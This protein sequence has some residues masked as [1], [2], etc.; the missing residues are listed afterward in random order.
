MQSET[1]GRFFHVW[2]DFVGSEFG[3][4]NLVL[5]GVIAGPDQQG[6]QLNVYIDTGNVGLAQLF[7]PT[8]P[9]SGTMTLQ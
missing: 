8:T 5:W 6:N 3:S 7:N 9:L 2:T 1:A 4:T